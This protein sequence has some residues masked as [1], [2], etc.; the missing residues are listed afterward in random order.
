MEG[1]LSLKLGMNLGMRSYKYVNSLM[2]GGARE[3]LGLTVY[4]FFHFHNISN[5]F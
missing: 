2:L 1:W 4:I 5:V 3:E